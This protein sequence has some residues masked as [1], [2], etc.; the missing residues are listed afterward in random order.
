MDPRLLQAGL[1]QICAV[2]DG[3][4]NAKISGI[5]RNSDD[6]TFFIVLEADVRIKK[7]PSCVHHS[8]TYNNLDVD[9]ATSCTIAT[10]IC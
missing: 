10:A 1:K 7:S 2:R 8:G 9:Q 4:Y 3:A 6:S 5:S